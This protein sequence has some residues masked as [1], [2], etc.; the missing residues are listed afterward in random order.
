ME[1][2]EEIT[3]ADVGKVPQLAEAR[4]HPETM[5]SRAAQLEVGEAK[6]MAMR[7][8]LEPINWPGCPRPIPRFMADLPWME[9]EAVQERIIADLLASG[10]VYDGGGDSETVAGRE[11][12]GQYLEVHDVAAYPSTKE[13][14]WGAYLLVDAVIEVDKTKVHR[15]VTIGAKQAVSVLAYAWACGDLPMAGTIVVEQTT[16][17][18][19]TI[20]GFRAEQPF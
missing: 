9:P 12:V 5:L 13:G 20:I 1:E 18:G 14:G 10:H 6:R 17:A 11:L 16:A 19:N 4:G 15:V 2:S 3:V 7:V 8:A